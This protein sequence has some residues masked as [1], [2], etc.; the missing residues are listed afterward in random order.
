[1]E[2]ARPAQVVPTFSSLAIFSLMFAVFAWTVLPVMGLASASFNIYNMIAMPLSGSVIGS[3]CAW[4][5]ERRIRRS[6]GMLRGEG[7]TKAARIM[8]SG[9]YALLALWLVI[10]ALEMPFMG[11]NKIYIH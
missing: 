10:V 2:D 4:I 1:M 7:L 5:A 11:P 8:A 3:I 9:Q 6:D